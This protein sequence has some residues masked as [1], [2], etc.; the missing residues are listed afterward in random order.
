[1]TLTLVTVRIAAIGLASVL[2]I[3]CDA[4]VVVEPTP[5][6]GA[7]ATAARQVRTPIPTPARSPTALPSPSPVAKPSPSS[8]PSPTA[9]NVSPL[10]EVAIERVERELSEVFASPDLAGI[11]EWLAERVS[12]ASAGGGEVLDRSQAAARLRGLTTPE[13]RL[14]EVVPAQLAVLL[15]VETEGWQTSDIHP[16]GRMTFNLHPFDAQGQQDPLSGEWK[17][18]IIAIE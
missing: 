3:G 12:I 5:V 7:A 15:Q 8:N 14:I 1:M 10:T 6:P 9:P 17:I 11:E 18:D 13:V 16:R 4:S 2:L